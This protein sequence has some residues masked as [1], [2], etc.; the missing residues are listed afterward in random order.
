[1][2]F[3]SSALK[4]LITGGFGYI[5]GRL[6]QYLFKHGYEIFL[7]TRKKIT[8][9]PFWL[10][11]ATVVETDWTCTSK[12]IQICD[13]MDIIIH[14]AGMNAQDCHKDF[15]AALEFNGVGTARLLQAAI[16]QKV[17]RFL[18]ISTAHVYGYPLIG[19]ITEETSPLNLDSYAT[20]HRAGED[21]VRSADQYGKI[22]GIVVRLSNA[23]GVPVQKE[24]DC[25]KLLVND[26][27]SQ[28][29]ITK[30]ICLSTSGVQRRD[31]VPLLDVCRAIE[32]L[33]HQPR[34]A[35]G[36]GLFN[37]GG[38]FA[39]TVWEFAEI[40]QKECELMLGFRPLLSRTS[41]EK[42]KNGVL[43]YQITAL[44]QIGFELKAD[45]IEEIDR[46]LRFCRKVF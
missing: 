5:G 12:L 35:L 45:P 40:I 28:A 42:E 8:R 11:Q 18:Y 19:N 7:G 39:P 29:V 3:G 41:Q 37:I 26:L 33:L 21:V 6:A 34:H 14:A 1:M 38:E 17:R 20:S 44:R 36:D 27:C 16:Q 43:Q 25:W 22:E 24:V 30:K 2:I 4:I 13:N 31:F 23:F 10:P 46:L 32:N 9:P 15:I